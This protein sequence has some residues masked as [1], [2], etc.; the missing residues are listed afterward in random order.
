MEIDYSKDTWKILVVDDVQVHR[1]L[2]TSGLGRLNPC[3]S[4]AEADG[5]AKATTMLTEGS[6]DVV[7]S[8]WN[9]PGG[10]GGE[11]VKWMRSRPHFRRVPFIMISGNKEGDD[12]IKA[13]MELGVDAYVVKPFTAQDLYT[14]IRMAIE[15]RR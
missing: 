13:F 6:Y 15:K 8:D 2:M 4:I 9:M 5:F 10:G 12:I 7:V 11:L 3:L 1:F 14:K